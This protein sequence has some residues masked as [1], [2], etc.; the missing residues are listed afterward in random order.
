MPR[1]RQMADEDVLDVLDRAARGEPIK[2]IAID[3][4]I[5]ASIV[6]K[7]LAHRLEVVEG[8]LREKR[9]AIGVCLAAGCTVPETAARSGASIAQVVRYVWARAQE[10]RVRRPAPPTEAPTET[11]A[12]TTA[13]TTTAAPTEP[14]WKRE[15]ED[16][17]ARVAARRQRR[18]EIRAAYLAGEPLHVIGLRFGICPS[19]VSRHVV[20]LPK[21]RPRRSA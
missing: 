10:E 18:E 8:K 4:G 1:R 17:A 2:S 9:A 16:R 19:A 11:T 21:R 12:E 7:Y 5:A 14:K 20:D 15:L 3:T 13:A 6:N